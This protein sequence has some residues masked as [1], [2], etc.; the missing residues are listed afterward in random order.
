MTM[1]TQNGIY[2][3]N[4]KKIAKKIWSFT[5]SAAFIGTVIAV[6]AGITYLNQKAEQER[7]EY[8]QS[9]QPNTVEKTKDLDGNGLDDLILKLNDGKKIPLF[10]LQKGDQVKYFTPEQ[11]LKE[12]PNSIVDYKRIESKLND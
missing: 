9:I 5:K 12:N 3:S 10:A 11:I 7:K 8:V 6:P 4:A 1:L 2:E